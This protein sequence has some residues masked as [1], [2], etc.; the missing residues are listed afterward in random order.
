M[1]TAPHEFLLTPI[2]PVLVVK[3]HWYV[4]ES[5]SEMFESQNTGLFSLRER[6]KALEPNRS[7]FNS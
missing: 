6:T 2:L 1:F 4:T 7:V 5:L 3:H